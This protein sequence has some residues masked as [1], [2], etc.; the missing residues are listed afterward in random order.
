MRHGRLVNLTLRKKKSGGFF[1]FF[2]KFSLCMHTLDVAISGSNYV[3]DLERSRQ[4]CPLPRYRS[5]FSLP[6]W[7]LKRGP[8]EFRSWL[9]A[10]HFLM[11]L[12]SVCGVFEIV[13][14]VSLVGCS[15]ACTLSMQVTRHPSPPRHLYL[16]HVC[17]HG[18]WGFRFGSLPPARG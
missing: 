2:F 3:V 14:F 8:S 15:Y 16:K 5:L 9:T 18:E 7:V 17:T 13:T 1:F 12:P 6:R 10:P 11:A 4:V